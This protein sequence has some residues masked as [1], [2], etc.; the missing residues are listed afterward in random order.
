[1]WQANDVYYLLIIDACRETPE[2]PAVGFSGT[3]D[4]V[5]RDAKSE[6]A[7]RWALC[8]GTSRGSLATDAGTLDAS[9]LGAFTSCVISEECGLFQPNVPVSTAIKLACERVR[10]QS[11]YQ[12]PLT[13]LDNISGDFCLH[14]VQEDQERFDVCVCYRMDTDGSG[15]RLIADSLE[16]K[17]KVFWR[18]MPGKQTERTQMAQAVCNSNVIILIVSDRTFADISTLTSADQATDKHKH[19]ANLLRQMDMILEVYEHRHRRC[20]V[21]PVYH[22]D[23]QQNPVT[24]DLMIKE[25]D[26]SRCWPTVLPDKALPWVPLVRRQALRDLRCV[27]KNLSRLL[28]DRYLSRVGCADV[29]SLIKGR[30]VGETLRA[31]QS[32]AAMEPLIGKKHDAGLLVANK[33]DQLLRGLRDSSK[34]ALESDGPEAGAA[35]KMPRTD[36]DGERASK[37]LGKRG[38]ITLGDAGEG[39]SSTAKKSKQDLTSASAAGDSGRAVAASSGAEAGQGGRVGVWGGGSGGDGGAV[40]DHG[41]PRDSIRSAYEYDVFISHSSDR[42]DEGRDNHARA[43]RLN[44]GL[45]KLKVKTWFDDDQMQGN[46]LQRRAEGIERSA[47][48]LICVTRKYMEKVAQDGSNNCKYEF[49]YATKKRT[50]LWML[51]VVMEE[52]MTDTTAWHGVLGM[53]LGNYSSCKLNSDADADFNCAVAKISES[54]NKMLQKALSNE[55]QSAASAMS[56]RSHSPAPTDMSYVSTAPATPQ[57]PQ[58]PQSQEVLAMHVENTV[59]DFRVDMKKLIEGFL[60]S[61]SSEGAEQ[62]AMRRFRLS[63]LL[64]V[65]FMKDKIA[66][67]PDDEIAE[68][69]EVWQEKCEDP[70]ANLIT[71]FSELMLS[72]KASVLND[73]G[74]DFAES[75]RQNHTSIFVMDWMVQHSKSALPRAKKD[76][77]IKEVVLDWF[78][79][80]NAESAEG[81]LERAEK[82]LQ[83]GVKGESWGAKILGKV[84]QTNS[85]VIFFRMEALAALLLQE[86][87]ALQTKQHT[88]RQMQQDLLEPATCALSLPPISLIVSSS[89]WHLSVQAQGNDGSEALIVDITRRLQRIASLP[90][91]VLEAD[92]CFLSKIESVEWEPLCDFIRGKKKRTHADGGQG[93]NA[94]EYGL[95]D[96]IAPSQ[97]ATVAP[98]ASAPHSSHAAGAEGGGSFSS[99]HLACVL[100]AAMPTKKELKEFVLDLKE[101]S[102]E[103]FKGLTQAST[104]ENIAECRPDGVIDAEGFLFWLVVEKKMLKKEHLQHAM[105]NLEPAVNWVTRDK[106]GELIKKI[107][108]DMRTRPPKR[109]IDC[110]EAARRQREGLGDGAP[111]GYHVSFSHNFRQKARERRAARGSA[112]V[113][114]SR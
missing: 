18:T 99:Q 86:H 49:E 8:A 17:G 20:S 82:F 24:F 58:S 5:Y 90:A 83:R 65:A 110:G 28:H 63:E 80:G 55:M 81:F 25:L 38:G 59:H 23:E 52:S 32:F 113:I 29:P 44:E 75:S 54:V 104:A 96:S 16:S 70:A 60:K 3:L 33:V 64:L 41:P 47:V 57:S 103:A 66:P 14:D 72:L 109:S 79:S 31:F 85:Y 89:N 97:E 40:V 68:N 39:S 87:C 76:E 105:D 37:A 77:W 27:D 111:C 35:F 53:V 98:L 4:P 36:D 15:A 112:C 71:A 43:K 69:L 22:G 114:R 73:I 13:L 21:L 50:P 100:S 48:V 12:A 46:V 61:P 30:Q 1:V 94:S 6:E 92:A 84:I 67:C 106:Q 91:Q 7:M 2:E 51:S 62:P 74:Y 26:R 56:S 42:D 93:A 45:Q 19:L 107:V 101:K 95:E 10:N 78:V 11:R 102:K 108:E 88:Q 34:R 9:H